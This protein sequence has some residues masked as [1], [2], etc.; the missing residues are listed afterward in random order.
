VINRKGG[1]GKSTLACHVAVWLAQR[2]ASVGSVMLADV[3]AQHTLTQWLARRR[4][5]N[6]GASLLG[7]VTD[8]RNVMRPPTGVQHSVLDSPGGLHGFELARLVVCADVV[9]LPVCDSAFDVDATAACLAELRSLPRVASGRVRL[10]VVGMRVTP[11]SAS[12]HGM[13]AWAQQQGVAFAGAIRSSPA[14]VGCA[15]SGLTLF[16]AEVAGFAAERQDWLPVLQ[17]LDAV[18]RAG[19]QGLPVRP[20]LPA[21]AARP[22]RPALAL[23]QT[24]GPQVGSGHDAGDTPPRLLTDTPPEPPPERP[25]GRWRWLF[26]LA[27]GRLGSRERYLV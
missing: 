9:L 1:C 15:T 26:G 21:P 13:A 11:D 3:D 20:A 8:A 4:Q 22:A 27:V 5:R 14:Y 25:G 19:P 18:L 16:D 17:W 23:R 12:A 7:W 2:S 6:P 10:A 24:H